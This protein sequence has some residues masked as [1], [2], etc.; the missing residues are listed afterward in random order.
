MNSIEEFFTPYYPMGRQ[1]FESEFTELDQVI[2]DFEHNEE[3]RFE[4]LHSKNASTVG[5]IGHYQR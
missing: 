2:L 5:K 4:E 3:R 1:L